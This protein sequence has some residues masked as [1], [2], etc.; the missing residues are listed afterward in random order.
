MTGQEL[1]ELRES[2][3]MK[4]SEL[5]NMLGLNPLYTNQR[6]SEWE[7]GHRGITRATETAIRLVIADW[8]EKHRDTIA[9]RAIKQDKKKNF[10]RKAAKM[11]K[12]S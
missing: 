8:Q 10:G 2:V 9:H 11:H 4:R 5:G 1:K 6:V 12:L 3:Y 7:H